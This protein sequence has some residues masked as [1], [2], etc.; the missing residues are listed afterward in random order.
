VERPGDLPLTA[1]LRD[2]PWERVEVTAR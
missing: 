2:L 1:A